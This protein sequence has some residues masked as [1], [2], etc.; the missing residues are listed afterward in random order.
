MSIIVAISSAV[1][2]LFNE[3]L[4][5]EACLA[6]WDHTVSVNGSPAHEQKLEMEGVAFRK[7]SNP[8]AVILPRG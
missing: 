3:R 4:S 2:S 8:S 7:L 6:S 1:N 5:K